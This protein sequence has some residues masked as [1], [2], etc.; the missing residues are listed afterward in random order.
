MAAS[1]KIIDGDQAKNMNGADRAKALEA[2]LAQIDRAFGKGSAMK[3]GSREAI[4]IDA[5]STGSLGLDIALGIGGLPKGRVIEIYGPES[6]GKTTLTL[7]VIAEAQKLGGTAAF[8]DAEHAL[9]PGYAKKLGVDIDNLIVSQPDTGEQAL[10]IADTLVRSN[11]VDIL[12]I[13]SVAALVPRAEIEG[14]MG[15]THVG[16]QA[17]LMSQALRKITGSISRSNCMV[18][19]INQI[20]MKI[21]VMYGSPETTTGG[22][23]LKFY[24]SVRLDIRR[25]G[26]VKQGEEIVGNTTKVKVVKNKVAP[27]FKQV[28]FDIMYGQG[29]S[30]TGE[31]LDLGVKAGLVEKSGS[32]FSYDSI[33]IGQGR[34]NSKAYLSENPEVAAK[35]ETA[36]RGKTEEVAEVMMTG[37]DADDDIGE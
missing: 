29:I 15:D 32:W 36:I 13:D 34:E 33:R 11:A 23:A 18:I 12:V 17:R 21:G 10:E 20:R 27:P 6:S 30:K 2:A 35:L 4:A 7:H 8:I 9:D 22:N 37:P 24:A 26:Q 3:L 19:F 16:L 5:I 14:E 25:T 31:L 28:E 1:L